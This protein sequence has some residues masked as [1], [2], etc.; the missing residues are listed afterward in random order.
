MRIGL[1]HADPGEAERLS[2][3]LSGAGYEPRSFASGEALDEAAADSGFDLLLMRWDG[4]DLCGVALMG[5]LR[6]K[7]A[8]PPHVILLVDDAAPGG[9]AE[10]A[11]HQLPDP[12]DPDALLGAVRHV[13]K[14][15]RSRS[16]A[17]PPQLQFDVEREQM[18]VQ[19]HRVQLTA[20]EF[21]LARLLLGNI[22]IPLS[23]DEIMKRVWGRKEDPGSR[24][25]DAHIAQVRKR[26][27]LR[28]EHGWRLSSVYGF[29]YRLDNVDVPTTAPPSAP[30]SE[31]TP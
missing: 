29:G 4:A 1:F 24:T 3:V 17:P 31:A 9:I 16:T 12:C 23:R 6:A 10:G 20:K 5:R 22:G 18:V 7:L 8:P 14:R 19:G 25:L 28:P 11:D 21:A 26:L 30:D 15:H 13:A 2:G 27:Q